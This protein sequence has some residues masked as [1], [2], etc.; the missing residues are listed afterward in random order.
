MC[1]K[2]FC[3]NIQK[4]CCI[5][6]FVKCKIT[7]DDI[8]IEYERISGKKYDYVCKKDEFYKS[9]KNW[10]NIGNNLSI[11]NKNF[12]ETPIYINNKYFS[13]Q[14]E[15]PREEKIEVKNNNGCFKYEI[16]KPSKQFLIN[17]IIQEIKPSLKV[18]SIRRWDEAKETTKSDVT[19]FDFLE[20]MYCDVITLKVSLEDSKKIL[21]IDDFKNMANS[22]IFY[23]NLKLNSGIVLRNLK[24]EDVKLYIR[25]KTDDENVKDFIVPDKIY[26]QCLVERYNKARNSIDPVVQYLYYYQMLEYFYIKKKSK[27]KGKNK[28]VVVLNNFI[29]VNILQTELKRID[30]DLFEYYKNNKVRFSSGSNIDFENKNTQDIYKNLADRIYSTRNALAHYKKKEKKYNPFHDEKDLLNEIPLIKLLAENVILA[31][32]KSL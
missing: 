15:Y 1:W 14:V 6:E 11:M 28:L 9:Y 21:N 24:N 5:F 17:L 31:N 3:T 10:N 27:V 19:I 18:L 32:S 7:E 16:S 30:N 12:Y 8:F 2:K 29:D 4:I 25:N 23:S 22:F 20:V 13:T 26:E